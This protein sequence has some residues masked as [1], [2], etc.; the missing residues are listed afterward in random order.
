MRLSNQ[1]HQT[2]AHDT[3]RGALSALR[4]LL[5][6][7]LELVE[8]HRLDEMI[9]EARRRDSVVVFP[10]AST[11][12]RDE[13]RIVEARLMAQPLGHGDTIVWAPQSDIEQDDIG[14]ESARRV[15]DLVRVERRNHGVTRE[16]QEL[17]DRL[18]YGDVVI[19]YENTASTHGD[20]P[21]CKL[22]LGAAIVKGRRRL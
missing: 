15:H 14:L 10:V 20:G 4:R 13:E 9:I 17:R 12:K 8:A 22:R 19:D 5:D 1:C 16:T 2:P 21:L 7:R 3:V 11:G 6:D 18:R